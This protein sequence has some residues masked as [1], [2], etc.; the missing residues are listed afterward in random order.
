MKSASS[1][2]QSLYRSSQN[3]IIAGVAGGLGEYFGIDPTIIRIIFIILTIFHGSGI[4]IYLIMWLVLPLESR[5][6]GTP[7]TTVKNNLDEMKQKTQSFAHSLHFNL[8]SSS[9]NSRFWWAILI[10]A[11]GFF[12]LFKNFGIF[13]DLDIGRFWPLILIVLGIIFILKK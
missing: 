10:I 12:F 1:T 2:P 7:E 3:K 11:I 9:T 6:S 8:G 5:G 13:D 4:L